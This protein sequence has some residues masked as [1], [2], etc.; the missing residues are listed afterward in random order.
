[1]P[2]KGLNMVID[3]KILEIPITMKLPHTVVMLIFT[4]ILL[5]S[6]INIYYGDKPAQN[7][8]KDAKQEQLD[9]I[10]A[11]QSQLDQA[12]QKIEQGQNVDLSNISDEFKNKYCY[13]LQVHIQS[14]FSKSEGF[15]KI[16]NPE[17]ENARKNLNLNLYCKVNADGKYND[18]DCFSQLITL[19]FN[20]TQIA[21]FRANHDIYCADLRDLPINQEKPHYENINVTCES[22]D[23]CYQAMEHESLKQGNTQI[24]P[25]VIAQM[26]QQN[27]LKCE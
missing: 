7:T 15:C 4:L 19:G 12:K 23:D 20:E 25:E 5:S 1:M 17:I 9:K 22:L 8:T 16:L 14:F 13:A 2:Q 27:M 6:C 3:Y 18:E 24:P 21:R 26:K 11:A 10:Q